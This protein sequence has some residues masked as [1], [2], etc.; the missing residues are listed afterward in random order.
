VQRE[1]DLDRM[2]AASP[3]TDPVLLV[4]NNYHLSLEHTV[5]AVENLTNSAVNLVNSKD[6]RGNTDEI[7]WL[8]TLNSA[9]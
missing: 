6:H 5:P 2:V 1:V 4:R 8:H 3:A 7:H 9:A